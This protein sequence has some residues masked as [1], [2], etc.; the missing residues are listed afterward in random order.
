MNDN[1]AK[2]VNIVNFLEEQ[3]GFNISETPP[4]RL[5]V[6]YRDL[7]K[8]IY[9][10]DVAN[11]I[12]MGVEFKLKGEFSD[13]DLLEIAKPLCIITDNVIQSFLDVRFPLKLAIDSYIKTMEIDI[14]TT[15]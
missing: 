5:M 15:E 6:I 9:P 13:E 8:D 11:K 7:L 12:A 4:F 14:D 3:K 2:I 1:L 10:I